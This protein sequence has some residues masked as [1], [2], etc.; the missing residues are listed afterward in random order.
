MHGDGDLV[1]RNDPPI[2]GLDFIIGKWRRFSYFSLEDFE[3]KTWECF[4]DYFDVRFAPQN[5]PPRAARYPNGKATIIARK[6]LFVEQED[7]KL[8]KTKL[9]SDDEIM[10][11]Y[12]HYFPAIDQNLVS[13]AY[14]TWPKSNLNW[15]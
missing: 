11:A 3:R 15:R 4:G 9:E 2:K 1:K 12:Q 14:S 13:L 6:S 8:K 7:R 5:F 10:K